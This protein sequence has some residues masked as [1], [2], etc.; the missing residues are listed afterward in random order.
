[1]PTPMVLQHMR[2]EA[3]GKSRDGNNGNN[4]SN[5]SAEAGGSQQQ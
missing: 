4:G 2:V 1:M 5:S 3:A